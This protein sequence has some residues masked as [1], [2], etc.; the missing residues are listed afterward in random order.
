MCGLHNNNLNNGISSRGGEGRCCSKNV[1]EHLEVLKGGE[2]LSEGS[3][4]HLCQ[5]VSELLLEENNVQ[6]VQSPVTIVG[7][8]HGQF[9]DLLRMLEEVG[10]SPP[11]TSYIFLGDYVDRGHNSVETLSL[12]LCL[13]AKYPGHITLL[14]GNHE[15]RQITQVYGF[16]DECMRKYG[17]ASAWRYCVS[18]FDSFGLAAII[19]SRVLCVHGGLSPEVRMIDQIRAIDRQQEI[20]H[21]GSFCD[22]V[23]SDPEDALVGVPWQISPRGAGYLVRTFY[24]T[25]TSQLDCLFLHLQILYFWMVN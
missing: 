15:S 1:D 24:N 18:A 16:Y 9:Y 19:D 20:P 11:Q 8:L 22:L 25:K 13:K 2:C 21:E 14:R 12:L 3:L 4:K 5:R 6:P 23:W 7:D 17:N 10:G